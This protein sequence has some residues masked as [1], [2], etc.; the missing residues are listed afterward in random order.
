MSK[1]GGNVGAW[2]CDGKCKAKC[3][4]TQILTVSSIYKVG[5]F[6]IDEN[7]FSLLNKSSDNRIQTP[8][9]SRHL[10]IIDFGKYFV[11]PA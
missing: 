9:F 10:K 4:H 11:L 3:I 6:V 2:K 7:L 8:D 1:P 5:I